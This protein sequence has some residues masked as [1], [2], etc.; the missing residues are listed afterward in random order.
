MVTRDHAAKMLELAQM[1]IKYFGMVE[2]ATQGRRS[3]IAQDE[4]FQKDRRSLEGIESGSPEYGRNL[5]DEG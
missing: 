3:Q 5:G 2:R 4:N 1:A